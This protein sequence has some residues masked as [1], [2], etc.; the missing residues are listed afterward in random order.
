MGLILLGTLGICTSANAQAS[1]GGA[2]AWKPLLTHDGVTFKYLFYREAN[3]VNNGVVILLTN[4][5]EYAIDYRFKVVFRSGTD[6]HIEEVSGS[7][8][9]G[10]SKT[11]DRDGLF[12][13]PFR[14]ERE[15]SEVGLRGY[16]IIPKTEHQ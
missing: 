7:L 16:K 9:A 12:W 15:I 10:E 14:D 8:K 6:Q 2:D 3:N 1:F 5:N 11:G 4:T 13:I